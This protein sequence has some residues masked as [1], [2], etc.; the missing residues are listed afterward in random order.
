MSK[1][2]W[3]ILSVGLSCAM[4]KENKLPVIQPSTKSIKAVTIYAGQTFLEAA[5]DHS[6]KLFLADL[7]REDLIAYEQSKN[8]ILKNCNVNYK[9]ITVEHGTLKEIYKDLKEK[10]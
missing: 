6:K 4:E 2:W 3:F 1:I 8:P 7:T 5:H 9:F 10:E